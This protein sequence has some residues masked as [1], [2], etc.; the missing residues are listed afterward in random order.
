MSQYSPFDEGIWEVEGKIGHSCW[1]LSSLQ[2]VT[3][4][5]ETICV[6]VG[7]IDWSQAGDDDLCQCDTGVMFVWYALDTSKSGIYRVAV[8]DNWE[9]SFTYNDPTL[10]VCQGES[11]QFVLCSFNSMSIVI[12]VMM[13]QL[14]SRH[15]TILPHRRSRV[16]IQVWDCDFWCTTSPTS[17]DGYLHSSESKATERGASHISPLCV[18][19]METGIPWLIPASWAL[20]ARGGNCCFLVLFKHLTGW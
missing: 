11:K 6:Y 3:M 7:W 18:M 14:P 16:Q 13:A 9:A 5:V 1:Q 12:I 19:A 4:T 10:E 8:N 20:V 2:F 17:C 15:D